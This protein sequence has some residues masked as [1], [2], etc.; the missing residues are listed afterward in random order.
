MSV[1]VVTAVHISDPGD[2]PQLF[3]PPFAKLPRNANIIP[4][5]NYTATRIHRTGHRLV[6]SHGLAG[7]PDAVGSSSFKT[8]EELKDKKLRQLQKAKLGVRLVREDCCKLGT[9]P[10]WTE[11]EG[12]SR[13]DYSQ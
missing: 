7:V 9:V 8:E 1:P 5:N 6:D 12:T 13:S 10:G 3:F 2:V 4:F 11:P